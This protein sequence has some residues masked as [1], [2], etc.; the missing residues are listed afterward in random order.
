MFQ[1]DEAEAADGLAIADIHLAARGHSMPYLHRPYDDA[2]TRRWFQAEIA[3]SP[4]TWWV[5]RHNGQVVGYMRLEHD[6]VSH[7]YVRPDSQGRGVGTALLNRA[8]SLSPQRLTLVTFQR[9]QAARSFY[10]A[11]G[12]TPVATTDGDNAEN[13]PDVTYLWAGCQANLPPAP[14]SDPGC[15]TPASLW[16]RRQ[17]N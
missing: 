6:E 15:A 17:S 7:L 14:I 11:R 3:A 5:A 2:A 13:E 12:F 9:N 10:E 1:L 8:K 4:R 16:A